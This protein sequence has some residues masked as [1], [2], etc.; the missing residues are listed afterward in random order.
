MDGAP[1]NGSVNNPQNDSQASKKDAYGDSAAAALDLFAEKARLRRKL[2]EQGLQ[3]W[4]SESELGSELGRQGPPDN[5]HEI[6]PT[7]APVSEATTVHPSQSQTSQNSYQTGNGNPYTP[8][9]GQTNG[10]SS[11]RATSAISRARAT[12]TSYQAPGTQ[13]PNAPAQVDAPGKS[14]LS[15]LLFWQKSNHNLPSQAALPAGQAGILPYTPGQ[16]GIGQSTAQPVTYPPNTHPPNTGIEGLDPNDPNFPST[17]GIPQPP[18]PPRLWEKQPYSLIVHLAAIAG[19]VTGAWFFGILVA[20]F[21]PGNMAKPPL[22]EA[23]LR[24]SSR[25][26]QRL[27]HF[28]KLW[29]TPTAHTRIEAIPLP[30][31]GPVLAPV[32]LSP[33]ERQPLIDELNAIETEVITLDRRIQT[34]EKRLGKPPYQGAD[35]DT[36]LNALRDAID[37]PKRASAQPDYTPEP[38]NPA[39]TL[40]EVAKL[41]ITLPSDA[42]FTPGQ[43][44]LKEAK[45]LN[46]VL[47]QLVNYPKATIVIRSHSDDQAKA[48]DSRAY[49]LEQANAL[50]TYLQAT[51]PGKHRWVTI[52]AG[53]SQPIA[54][55]DDAASRQQNRRIEILVDTR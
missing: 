12:D 20:Q 15:K 40:L 31:T 32:S 41:Q 33:I 52:G 1:V 6:S 10:L 11:P 38:Q 23:F 29:H 44:Q 55:N 26:T 4:A 13:Q 28:P 8:Y 48:K 22:Q 45:L 19:T 5:P 37:P 17:P 24:K 7:H 30:E 14:G 16:P 2:S 34:L 46:Q 35:I 47:D 42:L 21:L 3:N 51:L 50:G 36:R 27:W 9:P 53:Q 49:T 18:P 54:D 39:D 43:A 25:L